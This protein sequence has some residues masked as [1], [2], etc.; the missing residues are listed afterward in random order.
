M[1]RAINIAVLV[2]GHGRGSNMQ[3]I[4]DACAD[5]RITGKVAVVI[6]VKDDVPAM[7]R[8][9]SQGVPVVTVRPKEFATDEEYGRK[10]LEV[11]AEYG[12]DLICLA[13]YMRILPLEVVQTFQWRI[14]NTHAALIPS[15]CGKGMYGEHVHKAVLEYGVKISGC[16]IHFVD[17]QYDT[18]PIIVQKA[19]PVEEGDTPETLA[20]RILPNEHRAYVEAIQLF[21][22]GRLRVDGRVVHV[23]PK[24]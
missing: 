5:G 20:A 22:Q 6:G 1:D 2:S 12:V 10:L 24:D 21:A 7:E 18:G 4:I 15:F 17:E 13:G 9:R 14:M 19:V 11:L 3:T 16:T 8:A 23:L